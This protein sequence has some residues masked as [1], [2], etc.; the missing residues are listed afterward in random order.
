M[1]KIEKL[2]GLPYGFCG[3]QT[4]EFETRINQLEDKVNE[5]IEANNKLLEII[6]QRNHP[7][8]E[9]TISAYDLDAI[10]KIFKRNNPIKTA[11]LNRLK[12]KG[13]NK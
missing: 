3:D 12:R 2:K 10:G 1:E 9:K 6:Q 4:A 7:S 8:S 13:R 5:L 11:P